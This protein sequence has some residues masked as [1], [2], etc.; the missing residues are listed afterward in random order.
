M[1]QHRIPRKPS[2]VN[3]TVGIG[4]VAT[5]MAFTGVGVLSATPGVSPAQAAV[6]PLF[7]VGGNTGAGNTG[8]SITLFK[9][10]NN[11]MNMTFGRRNSVTQTTTSTNTSGNGSLLLALPDITGPTFA[12]FGGN[13]GTGNTGGNITLIDFSNNNTN[14][15]WG[16]RNTVDQETTNTNTSGNGTGNAS[17]IS[18]PSAS[19]PAWAIFGGNQGTD[20][21]GGNLYG[22][23]FTNNNTNFTWG[24]G[25]TVTQETTNTNSSGNTTVPTREPALTD[26]AAPAPTASGPSYLVVGG[27]RGTDNTGGN[28]SGINFVNNNTNLTLGRGNTVSQ[29]TTSSNTSG[30]GSVDIVRA[31][32]AALQTNT[33]APTAVAIGGNRG[34]QNTGG[35]VAGANIT[36]NNMNFSL[37]RGNSVTQTSRSTNSSGN[38]NSTPA[39]K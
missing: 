13:Q 36:N 38:A 32:A 39:Q 22:I 17:L 30:N 6:N 4:V 9:F 14:F 1:G 29:T 10:E 18:L 11:N 25:N 8:G 3:R 12:I 27:N 23:N 5:G 7:S 24:R 19:G 35:N 16:R 20:N 28:V 15:T 26:A 2:P 33:P 31:Q 34:T 37:G 21:T